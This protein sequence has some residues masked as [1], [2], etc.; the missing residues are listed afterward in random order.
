[1]PQVIVGIS[2][3]KLLP[4]VPSGDI[5][6][7]ALA[8][9]EISDALVFSTHG[10]F[11]FEYTPG[12]GWGSSVIDVDGQEVARCAYDSRKAECLSPRP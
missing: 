4:A 3:T 7:R 6:G 9:E 10:F 1:M 2:G 12:E 5:V 11:G 8:G